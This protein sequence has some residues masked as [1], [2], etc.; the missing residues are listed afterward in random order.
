MNK[1]QLK[2]II[3][4]ELTKMLF[5]ERR[6][7][8]LQLAQGEY[9]I[10]STQD[11]IEDPYNPGVIYHVLNP[12]GNVVMHLHSYDTTDCVGPASEYK[13]PA[14]GKLV[15]TSDRY[16]SLTKDLQNAVDAL[17]KMKG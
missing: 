2:Q 12:E 11:R 5:E 8:P 17:M 1:Q 4:E 13:D 6:G 7:T 16:D 3:K 10:V 15:Y 14:T 9:T